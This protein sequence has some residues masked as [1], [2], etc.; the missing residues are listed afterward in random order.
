MEDSQALNLAYIPAIEQALQ[1]LVEQLRSRIEHVES[2]IVRAESLLSR[3]TIDA[4]ESHHHGA[5][6]KQVFHPAAEAKD[7]ALILNCLGPDV[8]AGLAKAEETSPCL[9]L[10]E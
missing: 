2:E 7:E 10:L 9:I 4:I 3:T 5:L 8:L 6:P 1:M